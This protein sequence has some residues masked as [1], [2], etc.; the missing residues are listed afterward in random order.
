MVLGLVAII[1]FNVIDTF[2]VG[3]LGPTELAAMSFTFPVVVVVISVAM[4]IGVGLT[5][6][7]SRAIGQGDDRAVRRLTS[8]GL[9]LANVAV[10]AVALGGLVTIDPLFRALG[11]G[12]E[13][14]PLIREYMLPWYL[15]VGFIVIPMVGNSAIRAT[16]D[17][18]TPSL[19]MVVAGLANAIL[20]PF[21]IFG[22][23]PFPRLELQGAALATVL[24]YI[25]SFA[26]AI[27]ILLRREQML[28]LRI[29][30]PRE[31]WA[32]WKRILYVGVPSAATSML[33]PLATGILT[34]VVS[35][36]GPSAVAAYGVG[37][38]LEGLS[39][40]GVW[41][42]AAAITPFVGQNFGAGRY[43]R[44]RAAIRFALTFSIIYG[45]ILALLLALLAEP[46]ARLF[47][48]DDTVVA[49]IVRYLRLVPL[50]YGLYG[51]ILLINAVFNAV[52]RPFRSAVL[53]V[54]RLFVVAVPLALLGSTWFG[55]PGIFG[56]LAL[57][58]ASV[59]VVAILF[60]RR[61]VA[62]VEGGEVAVTPDTS[63]ATQP[64][65]TVS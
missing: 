48:E 45:A 61:F 56:A 20:D 26:A 33:V 58:N 42:M 43:D 62:R 9:I 15:G 41:A 18:R 34:R 7:I 36:Y 65:S 3:R 27:W 51:W 28:D 8:D 59:G 5:S 64:A 17:T 46:L 40:I 2:W 21:L 16:G 44:V 52:N 29:P 50:S 47:S 38:R 25:L 57:G 37:S 60:V 55:V 13:L 63:R 54:L 24:S 30:H 23:G 10:V 49:L 12:P 39:M 53:I 31:T 1:L 35:G 14:L 22:I 11:A 19:I 4:G 6:V 32:S